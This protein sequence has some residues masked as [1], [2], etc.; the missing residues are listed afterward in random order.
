MNQ[1]SP[2]QPYYHTSERKPTK[3]DANEGECVLYWDS[4]KAWYS[5]HWKEIEKRPD[6][7]AI[8]THQ[9]ASPKSR[10][11]EAFEKTVN[12]MPDSHPPYSF[13]QLRS[14]WL[15]ALAFAAGQKE[16]K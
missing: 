5:I 15:A 6:V 16:E 1:S 2:P 14:I 8:W 7:Y 3:E 9:P 11:E 13:L 10:E 12:G 4:N